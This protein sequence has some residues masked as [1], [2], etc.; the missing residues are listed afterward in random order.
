MKV[1]R[2]SLFMNEV[3][4]MLIQLEELYD[5]VDHFVFVQSE[6]TVQDGSKQPLFGTFEKNVDRFSKYMDK[7][8]ILN[9]SYDSMERYHTCPPMER[10]NAIFET[11]KV[12]VA[13]IYEQG[14]IADNDIVLFGDADEIPS[15]EV[16]E[17]LRVNPLKDSEIKVL[18]MGLYYFY[19][20]YKLQ[21]GHQG[22]DGVW[23]GFKALNVK[24]FISTNNIYVNI[25][26]A[27]DWNANYILD[28]IPNAGWHFSYFGGVESVQ[29]KMR[30]LCDHST[31]EVMSKEEIMHSM[32]TGKDLFGRDDHIWEI[33]DP[34]IDHMPNAIKNN[35]DKYKQWISQNYA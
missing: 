34:N 7:I 2:T 20:N 18:Q 27:H 16:V 19:L 1:I 4:L 24:T 25:R 11:L 30:T 22:A 3:D 15:R 8:T 28:A 6:V 14:L 5:V 29:N 17:Y 12:A 31:R 9:L 32:N 26:Q 35:P 33:I 10:R 21:K 13:S 23:N